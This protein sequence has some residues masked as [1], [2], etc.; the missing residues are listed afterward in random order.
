MRNAVLLLIGMILL[1]LIPS[2]VLQAVYGPSYNFPPS[3]DRW[4]PDGE[5]GWVKHGNPATPKPETPSVEVPVW[6]YYL[7]I[8]LPSFLLILFMFT[9]L[10]KHL[11]KPKASDEGKPDDDGQQGNG[12]NHAHHGN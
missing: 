5:G 6:A 7:P 3:E 8:F 2:L 9:P 10:R 11:E 4:M 1:Y 12:T